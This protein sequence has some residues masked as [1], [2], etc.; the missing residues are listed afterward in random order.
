MVSF[1]DVSELTP[2]SGLPNPLSRIDG[3]SI[4]KPD[5]W[6]SHREYLKEMLRH[7]MYGQMPP[8]PTSFKWETH[9]RGKTV[10]GEAIVEY[11]K[12][13]LERVGESVTI[14]VAILRPDR[15]GPFP[16]VIRNDKFLFG[17]DDPDETDMETGSPKN[18]ERLEQQA[19]T[20]RQ[21]VDR[22]YVLCNFLREDVARDTEGQR[23][24]GVFPLYPE[25]R[26]WGVITAWA[27]AYQVIVDELV[28]RPYVDADKIVV[29]GHSRGGKTAL[30]AGIYDERIAVTVP[31]SSGAGGTASWRF[32]DEEHDMQT[33]AVHEEN[34]AYWWSPRLMKFV[35]RE[36]CLPFDAH[37]NKAAI[38]PRALLNTHARHDWWANPYGTALTTKAAQPVFDWLNVPDHNVQH[39][40]DGG[41]D[42]A[43]TDWLALFDFCDRYFFDR[44][45]DRDFLVNPYPDRYTFDMA[46]FQYSPTS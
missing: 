28:K 21:A 27:W 39:W 17:P 3:T 20:N 26:E 43:E 13:R 15:S 38:A 24:Q 4:T 10:E 12:L 32:F 46:Q 16:V 8:K 37:I 5:D 35:G 36:P 31:N 34:R 14:R 45:T 18:S 2:Q 30:C 41:H 1:P 29:T 9:S 25:Y 22:G 40:R 33:L 6:P 42:Q 11:G 19:F 7:Y 23:K 44:S